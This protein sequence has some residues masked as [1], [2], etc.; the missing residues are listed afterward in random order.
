MFLKKHTKKEWQYVGLASFG[1][2]L[3]WLDMVNVSS[4]DVVVGSIG[5]PTKNVLL[6]NGEANP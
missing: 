1:M 5:F 2:T 4:A 3:L 6:V